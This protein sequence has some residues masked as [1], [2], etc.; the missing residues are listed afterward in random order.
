MYH[1]YLQYITKRHLLLK[2]GFTA[3][4]FP[5]LHFDFPKFPA[6]ILPKKAWKQSKNVFS[7]IFVTFL[8][9]NPTNPHFKIIKCYLRLVFTN[10]NTFWAF[11]KILGTGAKLT[12]REILG[13]FLGNCPGN[14]PGKRRTLVKSTLI[15]SCF[16]ISI[17]SI[18]NFLNFLTLSSRYANFFWK[19]TTKHNDD[20]VAVS[21][22]FS[23][24]VF[25]L[26]RRQHLA[27]M[28]GSSSGF[29]IQSEDFP[30]LPGT[31]GQAPLNVAVSFILLFIYSLNDRCFTLR[32]VI[33]MQQLNLIM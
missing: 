32:Y 33:E 22:S 2:V 11:L 30:A 20:I 14:F 1:F 23:S 17:A 6:K 5:I 15:L 9:K 16:E 31:T 19:T 26:I 13:N 10:S 27:K 7:G 4:N 28:N 24:F 12:T 3:G 25:A 18:W 21:N 29:K 8:N